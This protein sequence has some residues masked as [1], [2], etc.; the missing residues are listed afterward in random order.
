M[1]KSDSIHI[2]FCVNDG[3]VPYVAVTIKS[4]AENHKDSGVLIYVLSDY[5]SSEKRTFLDLVL[6]PYKNVVMSIIIV[7]DSA[8]RGLKDT[9]TIYTWYRVLL[10]KYLPNDVHRV[11]YLD[12][13]TIV[14]GNIEELFSL[15]MSNKAV[16]G[17]ID[18]ESFKSETF[19][20]CM[21]D[22]SK[23]YICA[24]VLLM[25][26]DYWRE[27]DLS[28]TIV[29]WGYDHND[30]IRFPDQDTINVLC[31]DTK[32]VLPLR[33]GI[34]DYFFKTDLFYDKPYARELRDCIE[35]P[36]IIHYA[37]MN[38]WKRELATSLMQDEWEKY[39]KMLP[40]PVE[41]EYITKGWNL[42]KMHVWNIFHPSPKTRRLTRK[43]V[44][45][46]LNNHQ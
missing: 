29:K 5:I 45:N 18:P 3:Y 16:A 24:G 41:K 33:Y 7:D 30:I 15:D 40:H 12:A 14:A 42:V 32:I 39:N 25:N 17:T 26:L 1:N 35:H 22:A 34:M 19:Q 46:R 31:Q 38:P 21:Y 4:V 13:D 37:G 43:E 9:W 36:A 28:K 8:L 11:L 27:H 44:L 2:A 10:P 23:R 6:K 20:R